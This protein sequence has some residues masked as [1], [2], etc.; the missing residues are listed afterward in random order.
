MATST[1]APSDTSDSLWFETFLANLAARLLAAPPED[2]DGT[3]QASLQELG[4]FLASERGGIGL[5]SEDGSSLV[6]RY[7]YFTPESAPAALRG[8]LRAGL[9]VVRRRAASR[10][11]RDRPPGA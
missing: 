3:I 2:V 6:F 8:R 10:T 9:A 11:A 7:G 1:F 5:F 4:A